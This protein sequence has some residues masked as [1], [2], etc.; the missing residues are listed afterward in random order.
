MLLPYASAC[1]HDVAV[2]IAMLRHYITRDMPIRRCYAMP[3]LLLRCF[4]LCALFL[5]RAALRLML[6]SWPAPFTLTPDYA[7]CLHI[8][9]HTLDTLR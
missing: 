1:R 3:P 5:I 7:A 2:A 4:C 6:A 8:R 9:Y